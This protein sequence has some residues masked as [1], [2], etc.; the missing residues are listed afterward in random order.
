MEAGQ[1]SSSDVAPWWWSHRSI[2]EEAE[3][4][5]ATA[6]DAA[7]SCLS[8]I[9]KQTA[10]HVLAYRN[11]LLD[12]V[13]VVQDAQEGSA[14]SGSQHSSDA[15]HINLYQHMKWD[16]VLLPLLTQ[17]RKCMARAWE[18]RTAEQAEQAADGMTPM[19]A[20]GVGRGSFKVTPTAHVDAVQARRL[21]AV[22]QQI[23]LAFLNAVLQGLTDGARAAVVT[24]VDTSNSAACEE[25]GSAD[26]QPG[27]SSETTDA[28]PAARA[29]SL[30]MDS[31]LTHVLSF[32]TSGTVVTSP[33]TETEDTTK[34]RRGQHHRTLALTCT[35]TGDWFTGMLPLYL[36]AAYQQQQ[37]RAHDGVA[38]QE[39]AASAS[40]SAALIPSPALCLVSYIGVFVQG[41]GLQ[42]FPSEQEAYLPCFNRKVLSLFSDQIKGFV[43]AAVEQSEYVIAGTTST[44]AVAVAAAHIRYAGDVLKAIIDMQLYSEDNATEVGEDDCT[45]VYAALPCP[46]A[47][48]AQ[49]QQSEKRTEVD[50]S[51]APLLALTSY[52]VCE[53]LLGLMSRWWVTCE[54]MARHARTCVAAAARRMDE[55]NVEGEKQEQQQQGA[56]SPTSGN[57]TSHLAELED[58]WLG[59]RKQAMSFTLV[60]STYSETTLLIVPY[61]ALLTDLFFTPAPDRSAPSGAQQAPLSLETW[62]SCIRELH[63]VTHASQDGSYALFTHTACGARRQLRMHHCHVRDC[64]F[65]A[66]CFSRAMVCLSDPSTGAHVSGCATEVGT[67]RQVHS[68][69]PH[70]LLPLAFAALQQPLSV[71]QEHVF[72]PLLRVSSVT[73]SVRADAVVREKGG[74]GQH[75]ATP[76]ASSATRLEALTENPLSAVQLV[77]L[78]FPRHYRVMSALDQA[79]QY[80]LDRFQALAS[81][82]TALEETVDSEVA[83]AWASLCSL[84]ATLTSFWGATMDEACVSRMRNTG[85]EVATSELLMFFAAVFRTL[86]PTVLPRVRAALE[87]FLGEGG[88]KTM[89]YLR[90]HIIDQRRHGLAAFFLPPLRAMAL[91]YAT[92]EDADVSLA[93]AAKYPSGCAMAYAWELPRLY[94]WRVEDTPV[95]AAAWHAHSAAQRYLCELVT[96]DSAISTTS[97]APFLAILQGAA[98]VVS[99]RSAA[100]HESAKTA[101]GLF[102]T[103]SLAIDVMGSVFF[104]MCRWCALQLSASSSSLSAEAAATVIQQLCCPRTPSVV[105]SSP[106]AVAHPFL[107]SLRNHVKAQVGNNLADATEVEGAV[108]SKENAED[109][110]L[111]SVASP[112]PSQQLLRS[113][114]CW[115][116]WF[117][118]C[119]YEEVD[120]TARVQ[121]AAKRLLR[122]F[123]AECGSHAPTKTLLGIRAMVEQMKKEISDAAVVAGEL[124]EAVHGDLRALLLLQQ[125]QEQAENEKATTVASTEDTE[126]AATTTSFAA[127]AAGAVLK[128]VTLR[129]YLDQIHEAL[130]QRAR[131]SPVDGAVS[132]ATLGHLLHVL[133]DPH[134]PIT[135][136]A[137]ERQ[138]MCQRLFFTLANSLA[139]CTRTEAL[140]CVCCMRCVLQ[141]IVLPYKKSFMTE[142]SA[143]R[144][145]HRC[146]SDTE[147]DAFRMVQHMCDDVIMAVQKIAL[148]SG[149]LD[150]WKIVLVLQH[151]GDPLSL[152]RSTVEKLRSTVEKL[153]ARRR[154]VIMDVIAQQLAIVKK[155]AARTGCGVADDVHCLFTLHPPSPPSSLPAAASAKAAVRAA[156]ALTTS[157]SA[158]AMPAERSGSGRRRH[159]DR[160]EKER[161]S[162]KD[163]KRD[164]DDSGSGDSS[165]HPWKKSRYRESKR[166]RTD[167]KRTRH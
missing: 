154:G 75:G 7:A 131:V 82:H 150:E 84:P 22:Q 133:S 85:D 11:V 167:F 101:S 162:E 114:H 70:S 43:Q 72:H 91:D 103:R 10:N 112:S 23:Y 88:C 160:R 98:V 99:E 132:A 56:D 32:A 122:E 78:Y 27:S 61:T 16:G 38:E 54:R 130:A 12:T 134:L 118:A 8:A 161:R 30:L 2:V 153:T 87:T 37:Q 45:M 121:A 86:P 155:S 3:P 148:R 128:P 120:S 76:D 79:M 164:R 18:E 42:L 41:A 20:S 25:G 109:V 158:A 14:T 29:L 13:S 35:H 9:V 151:L 89:E 106:H 28:A 147:A 93:L 110:D 96:A 44:D 139:E 92:A 67:D 116:S 144:V 36:R 146:L 127:A 126:A 33:Q 73:L 105:L 143:A 125:Q 68:S 63:R 136:S 62:K 15:S 58:V 117:W 141:D 24:G 17:L 159:G 47:L 102:W 31:L 46:L 5:D 124:Q 19:S 52:K 142:A 40:R 81:N 149:I 100:P 50:Y 57:D 119:T 156:E 71:M 59:L 6:D 69:G 135:M 39:G 48:R 138:R 166:H 60:L 53:R 95:V 49:T 80:V 140:S 74:A 77:E 4:L 129:G 64:T 1:T 55:D 104:G 165:E 26:A 115:I 108:V 113:Q 145:Y 107:L 66:A 21:R 51:V 123:S 34:P 90:H 152:V 111:P 83:M 97:T 137:Q 94:F 65:A 157:S 163:R